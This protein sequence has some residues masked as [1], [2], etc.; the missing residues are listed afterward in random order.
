MAHSQNVFGLLPP[1][2]ATIH[3]WSESLDKPLIERVR[4]RRSDAAYLVLVTAGA[5]TTF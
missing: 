5:K 4:D 3:P 2:I 1:N